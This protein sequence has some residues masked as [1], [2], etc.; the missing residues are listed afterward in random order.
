MAFRIARRFA[1]IYQ[2][3]P[4][5]T[6]VAGVLALKIG[7]AASNFAAGILL[8]RFLGPAELGVYALVISSV[9]LAGQVASLG[10]GE[11]VTR[12]VAKFQ[13]RG[14]WDLLRG[15]IKTSFQWT[16]WASVAI[17]TV[18]LIIGRTGAG[19]PRLQ[20]PLLAMAALIIPFT[21][22]NLLRSAVL[23]GLHLVILADTPDLGLRSFLLLGLAIIGYLTVGHAGATYAVSFQFAAITA[24]YIFGLW[25]MRAKVTALVPHSHSRSTPKQWLRQAFF[26][27]GFNSLGQIEGQIALF[28]LGYLGS[29]YQAG[30]YQP[31]IQAS[32]A[33][34][35]GLTAVNI[36]LR[37]KVFSAWATGEQTEVQR[38][39]TQGGKVS[40]AFALAA[41]I[42]LLPF[43][44]ALTLL[45]G[46]DFA[47]A[48]API[49]LLAVGQLVSAMCGSSGLVVIAAGKQKIA[50]LAFSTSICVDT[51]LSFLLVPHFGATGSAIAAATGML[52]WKL[53]L[54]IYS[55]LAL[56]VYTP[57]IRLSRWR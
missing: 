44:K 6:E 41:A 11:F 17:A 13:V 47:A 18:A 5:L 28:I 19:I 16:S 52:T 7:S 32:A 42:V 54:T 26:F 25:L 50:M 1:S 33:L 27:F 45:Y 46:P 24:A 31:A 30:L 3:S 53:V 51:G 57:V 40:T 48:A 2:R 20:W 8:A 9:T 15:V 4:Y 38:L 12:E 56:R 36:P 23:R 35:L 21:A 14:E 34:L 43:A 22:I 37:P 39:I 55:S 49:R 29:A 10:L